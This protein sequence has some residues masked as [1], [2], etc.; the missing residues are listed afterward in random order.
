VN[1][2]RHA[3]AALPPGTTLRAG[4]GGCGKSRP[5]TGIRSP[6]RP[7]RSEL[8]YRMSYP[9]P[10]LRRQGLL[11]FFTFSYLRGWYTVTGLMQYVETVDYVSLFKAN[12]NFK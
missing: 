6:D 1:G 9:D 5:P 7:N 3:P 12:L 8:L 11:H 10:P 4:L 2:Q